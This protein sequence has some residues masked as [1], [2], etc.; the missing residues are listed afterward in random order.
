MKTNG[1]SSITSLP[2]NPQIKF[3]LLFS[4]FS[5]SVLT[6]TIFFQN[7]MRRMFIDVFSQA[8]VLLWELCLAFP[9]ATRA[10]I[11]S[12][13]GGLPCPCLRRRAVLSHRSP[14]WPR[15]PVGQKSE[16][17]NIMVSSIIL[18]ITIASKSLV[19]VIM[20]IEPA[21]YGRCRC[22][23]TT[24]V[25]RLGSCAGGLGRAEKLIFTNYCWSWKR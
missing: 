7:E 18:T 11:A 1:P 12:P 5:L 17:N 3:F 25:G 8:K 9:K 21:H 22:E 19:N 10:S 4:F 20:T 6:V 16:V 13:I 2:K 14:N 15:R 23:T 24:W